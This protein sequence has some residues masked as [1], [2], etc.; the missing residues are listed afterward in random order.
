M[1]R[2]WSERRRGQ[3]PLSWCLRGSGLPGPGA[4]AS[5][6]ISLSW[7]QRTRCDAASRLRSSSYRSQVSPSNTI[8]RIQLLRRGPIACS[9]SMGLERALDL[10]HERPVLKDVESLLLPLPIR[11]ADDDEVL[12][13]TPLHTERDMILRHLL[14]RVPQ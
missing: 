11:S 4:G 9:F 14:D 8:E 7:R 10:L 12:T 5:R 6:C 3:S 2:S 13:S 1:R